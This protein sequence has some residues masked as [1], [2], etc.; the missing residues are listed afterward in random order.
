[1]SLGTL[2]CA[3]CP[4]AIVVVAPPGGDRNA[5]PFVAT[6]AYRDGVPLRDAKGRPV[7]VYA[8]PACWYDP[9]R[10]VPAPVQPAPE[11]ETTTDDH[12]PI[13][14]EQQTMF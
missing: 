2:P 5:E 10:A 3:L 14:P 9:P 7:V 12:R 8:H 11:Q 13:E 4:A 6:S 1:M